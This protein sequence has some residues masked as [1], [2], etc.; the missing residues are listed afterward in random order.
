MRTALVTGVSGYL[1]GHVARRLLA[2]GWRVIALVRP[3]SMMAD[4]LSGSVQRAEYDGTQASAVDAFA[5][6]PI[7]VVVH[8]ASAVVTNHT[9]DQVD[10]ILDANIRFP[11]HLLEA[12]RQSACKLFV[13]TGTF[14]QHCNSDAYLPVNLYA[15]TK[16]AFEDIARAY[17]END[18]VRLCTLILFDTYGADDPRR[19][20]LRLL[21]EAVDA[22]EPLLMSPGEQMLDLTHAHDVAAA[23][24]VACRRLL[25]AGSAAEERFRVSGVRLT[26]KEL[27]ALVERSAGKALNIRL[28][29]RPYREREIMDP[30]TRLPVLPGWA[31]AHSLPGEIAA[32][33]NCQT[34]SA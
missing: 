12:M 7:D 19:K 23:F 9:A 2:E 20:I 18:G 15:A 25:Q 6:A 34:A 10:L 3:G 30:I 33:L 16:Q 21:A 26:L 31:P 22:P 24:A 14:W 32:M 28:G 29:A 1:G 17:V 11:V 8:L 27:V 5:L 13:N 4:D